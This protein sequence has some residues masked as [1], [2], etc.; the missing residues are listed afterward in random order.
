MRER[1]P[2]FQKRE[3][4]LPDGRRLIYYEFPDE[5]GSAGD[6]EP[7]GPSQGPAPRGA[8]DREER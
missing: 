1:E 3:L 8:P 4:R 6:L 2:A 7:G 5:T